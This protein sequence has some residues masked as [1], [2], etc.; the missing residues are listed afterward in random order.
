M[1]TTNT[2]SFPGLFDWVFTLDRVAIKLVGLEIKWYGVIICL[3][4]MLAMAYVLRRS[5]QFGSN[6]DQMVDILLWALPLGI[7]GARVYYVVNR[8]DYY[9]QNPSQIISIWEGGLAIYGGII[10]G[11]L[12]CFIYCRIKKIDYLSLFDLCSIGFLIG[13][14]AGRWGNFVNAEAFG[15]LTNLPWGMSINGGAPVHPTFLY[16]SLWNLAGLLFLHFYAKR[17][18]FPG[19]MFLIYIGW[20]GLGRAWIEGLRTDSLYLGSTDIR[21]SQAL[22]ALCF[23]AA[24]GLLIYYYAAKKPTKPLAGPKNDE[25][26]PKHDV[27]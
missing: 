25:E 13:Q 17:R 7:L 19:E 16:E 18:K 20:Y 23:L 5:P 11:F 22:A 24:A 14:T 4:V 21:I 27:D 3:G 6:P 8:W 1:Q 15:G 2:V 10:A 26:E 9:S 12:T